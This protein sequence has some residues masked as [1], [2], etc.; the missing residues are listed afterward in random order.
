MTSCYWTNFQRLSHNKLSMTRCCMARCL[1]DMFS[2][3]SFHWQVYNCKL[4]Y[5]KLSIASWSMTSCSI[6]LQAFHDKFSMTIFPWHVIQI[7]S[8]IVT[9]QV[10]LIFKQKLNYTCLG[11]KLILYLDL[12]WNLCTANI[13]L[14]FTA[15]TFFDYSVSSIHIYLNNCNLRYLESKGTCLFQE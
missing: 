7:L 9:T 8:N 3:T 13:E 1:N 11:K 14:Y 4:F 12:V 15:S 6:L 2:K 10:L 5:D